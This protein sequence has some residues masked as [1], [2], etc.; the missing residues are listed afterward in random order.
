[1]GPHSGEEYLLVL[2]FLPH[3]I[4]GVAY[5]ETSGN[6]QWILTHLHLG[7]GEEDMTHI[8]LSVTVNDSGKP[9]F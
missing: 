7:G 5:A 8:S 1:M 6:G 4:L 2:A 3:A 9:F